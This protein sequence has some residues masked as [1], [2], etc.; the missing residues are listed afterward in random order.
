MQLFTYE[1]D[2]LVDND[3]NNFP[4]PKEYNDNR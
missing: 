4:L 2:R 1:N 3:N